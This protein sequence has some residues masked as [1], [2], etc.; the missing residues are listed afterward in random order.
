MVFLQKNLVIDLKISAI[1]VN[2]NLNQPSY[3]VRRIY[4]HSNDQNAKYISATSL[5]SKNLCICLAQYYNE[6]CSAVCV[7]TFEY[8][9]VEIPLVDEKGLGGDELDDFIPTFLRDVDG[10]WYRKFVRYYGVASW[11]V[12]DGFKR[13]PAAVPK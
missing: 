9:G 10:R 12:L 1:N 13:Y 8:F 7:K 4:F 2:N 5:S 3:R 11:P 6:N